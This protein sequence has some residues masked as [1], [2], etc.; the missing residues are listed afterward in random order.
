MFYWMMTTDS[1]EAAIW[2]YNV[3][4]VHE[5]QDKMAPLFECLKNENCLLDTNELE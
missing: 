1:I 5:Q 4:R 3:V 2:L